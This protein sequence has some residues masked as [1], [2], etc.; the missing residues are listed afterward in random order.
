[1]NAFFVA[2]GEAAGAFR[3]PFTAENHYEPLR[4]HLVGRSGHLPSPVG[5]RWTTDDR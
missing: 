5:R 2:A 4:L 1:V 3:E